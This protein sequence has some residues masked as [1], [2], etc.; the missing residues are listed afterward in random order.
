MTC[1]T[2]ITRMGRTLGRM[3]RTLARMTRILLV[4][5]HR[6]IQV[7]FAALFDRGFPS[8]SMTSIRGSIHQGHE[9]FSENSRGRQCTFVSHAAF[10]FL[11]AEY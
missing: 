10:L 11:A 9:T 4:Q 3:T 1:M 7:S 6:S 5:L 8:L 2:R